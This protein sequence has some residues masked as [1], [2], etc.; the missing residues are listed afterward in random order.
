VI[1]A[2]L[3]AFAV[4]I[5]S[6]AAVV[7]TPTITGSTPASPANDNNPVLSGTAD[8]GA[9]VD[10]FSGICPGG[11][12]VG[13][14]VADATTGAFQLPVSVADDTTTNFFA[15]ATIPPDTSTCSGP[16]TYVEASP[17]DTTLAPALSVTGPDVSF[18]FSGSDAGSGVA[19]FEC[20]LDAANFTACSSP[21][22]YSGLLGG[23]HTFEVRGVD[24]VGNV[25]PTPAS[26]TWT[27]DTVSPNVTFTAKP[28]ALTNRTT[29]TFAFSA[30]KPG[31]SFECSLDGAAF[32]ACSR[33]KVYTGLGNGLHTV[34]VHAL[35]LG[36]IGPPSQY[37]WTVDLIAPQ[38]TI[39]S[40]PPPASTS[41]AATFTFTGSE[42]SAFTCRLDGAGP[43][44]CTSP[45]TYTGLG[46]GEHTFRV[47]A[48]DR[49]GN[50]DATPAGYSW[51]ISGVGP[52]VQDLRPPTNVGRLRRSVG[53]G[54]M[55]L[56]WR[57]PADSDFDHVA[58]FATTKRGA[59]PRTLVYQGKKQSYVNRRFQNGFYYRYLVVSYDTSDNASGGSSATVPPSALLRSPR[60]GQVVRSA[61]RLRWT[62][63][64]KATY[65]NV[66]L[67]Y[68]GRKVLSA[69][70]GRVRQALAR[71]WS[72]SGRSYHLRKGAYAWFVWP[73]FGPRAKSR[74]GSLLGV[75]T[76]K[77]R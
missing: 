50:S 40:A 22:N 10:V 34:A 54:V 67:Y 77:V 44:P 31:S 58:V 53:Y 52:P 27:V 59:P 19:G 65:Y 23:P 35:W 17:P 6:A 63:V 71:R 69:W 70:P 41:A 20:S 28:P 49:A 45:K 47:Q 26:H 29:A 75:G 74:Y 66:Q 8:T 1:G 16:F 61:P 39:G 68:H 56:R 37:S 14:T 5:P 21:K 7:N 33:P 18:S 62:P 42:P 48:V 3:A 72:Y 73:G 55:K 64:R 15:T 2:A 30:D 4:G 43:S 46:D 11:T 24:A 12:L 13:T 36:L 38:T 32:T 60:D 76:F 9:T 25:D 51:R 57:R